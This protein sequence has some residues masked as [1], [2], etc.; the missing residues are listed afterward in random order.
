MIGVLAL[1]LVGALRPEAEGHLAGTIGRIHYSSI[2][3][4][5]E[6][7]GVPG[8]ALGDDPKKPAFVECVVQVTQIEILCQNSQGNTV[9]NSAGINIELGASLPIDDDNIVNK[10][11][12]IASVTP[13]VSDDP[14]LDPQFCTSHTWIPI[15]VLATDITVTVL[16]KQCTDSSCGTT[17]TTSSDKKDCVIPPGFTVE[18]LPPIGTA[19]E[20]VNGP[21]LH[22]N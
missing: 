19:Y 22:L 18:N 3:C 13:I 5:T 1:G 7:S 17:I 16:V 6:V 11:K 15:E 4:G 14:L 21:K 20:C 8:T 10:K 9:A 12:G 2:G